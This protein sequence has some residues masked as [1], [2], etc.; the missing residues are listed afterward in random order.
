V[1]RIVLLFLL[2]ACG[3]L[4]NA[5]QLAQSAD[6]LRVAGEIPELSYSILTS[7]SVLV[8]NTL[9]FHRSTLKSDETKALPTDY[10]HL[11]SNT[12]AITGLIAA[13]LVE[14]RKISWTAKLFALFPEW[15][16]VANPAYYEITLADLL[17]HRARI[18]PFTGGE[19]FQALPK[20][21]GTKSAQR[22]LFSYYLLTKEPITKNTEIYNYSNAGYSIA[23]LM[24]EQASGKTWEDLVDEVL[25]KKLH[26]QYKF[27]WPNRR[28][29]NQPS[30]H[31]LEDEVLTPLDSNTTYNL[32]LIEPAGDISMPIAD[33]VK[34]IQLN[35]AGLEGKS[36][37]VKPQTVNYLHFG[38]P[39]YSIGW[40]NT[41]KAD[42]HSSEHAGSAGTFYC[43]TLINKDKNLAYVIMANSATDK[44]LDSIFK[45][46]EQMVRSAE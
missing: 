44:A 13:Y 18:Q 33:Y 35:L 10:M 19:E 45:L 32:N 40:L 11:G 7:D 3:N 8:T 39:A 17:S 27:G 4:A 43:Y 46:L 29:C 42:K 22:K 36:G 23:A 16:A 6:S 38:H 41:N 34:F 9:G 14:Q 25:N 20:F 5:Q 12:K 2:T 30:G 21:A 24:L 15:R 37:L 28:D 26:L 31:W 1:R